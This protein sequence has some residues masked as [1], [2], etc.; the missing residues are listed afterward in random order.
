MGAA[1]GEGAQPLDLV[2]GLRQ[3]Q[4]HLRALMETLATAGAGRKIKWSTDVWK[5]H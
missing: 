2:F 4:V 1:H 5:V 3:W